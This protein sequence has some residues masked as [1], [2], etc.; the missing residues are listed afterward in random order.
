MIQNNEAPKV[1]RRP[2][3]SSRCFKGFIAICVHCNFL[4]HMLSLIIV[5]LPARSLH[6]CHY[7]TSRC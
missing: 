5:V 1:V 6:D 2:R 4:L 3:K 7:E